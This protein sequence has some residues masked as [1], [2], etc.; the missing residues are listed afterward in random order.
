MK[1][2]RVG[3]ANRRGVILVEACTAITLV[4]LV[5]SMVSLLVTRHARAMDFLVNERRAQLAA[6]SY[7]ERMRAG[8]VAIADAKISEETGI[9]C[10]VHV[11]EAEK[12]WQPLVQVTV[13]ASVV[14]KHGRIASY[15]LAT[16]VAPKPF[17]GG[18]AP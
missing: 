5:L 2:W 7:V 17:A 11:T 3:R 6:V 15:R 12:P 13:T 16:F 18:P 4:G 8:L 1:P 9:T 10:D 14:G